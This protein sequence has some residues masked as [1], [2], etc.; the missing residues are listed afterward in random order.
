[1]LARTADNV[2]WLG[3]Y[4]ERIDFL[5][6]LMTAAQQM[7]SVSGEA[8]EWRSTLITAGC[9]ETFPESGA[10]FSA[11][12]AA[13]HLACDRDNPSSL[14]N[15]IDRARQNARAVRTALSQDVWEAVNQVWLDSQRLTDASFAPQRL[16]ETLDTMKAAA[17]RFHGAMSTTLLHNPSRRFMQLGACLE[18]A[19][20]TARILDVKYNLLLPAYSGVGGAL[21]Y[22]QWM[23]ILQAVSATRSY[24]W[25]YRGQVTPLKVAELL[26]LRPEL[27]R[28]LRSCFDDVVECLDVIADNH[29]GARGEPHRIAGMM[30][31]KLRFGRIDDIFAFG[32]HEY[33]T[34]VVD[35][36]VDLGFEISD[37]YMR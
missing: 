17:M 26:L 6:R 13:R 15:C 24:H 30:A 4:M 33:L 7:A 3:R 10:E 8:E 22:Y 23:S 32:L 12:N 21:D 34:D 35:R 25:V 19:D 5:A 2:F 18:R 28:S 20:N 1:M 27:P 16:P 29:G 37:L 36:C 11:D 14:L 31:S 9:E